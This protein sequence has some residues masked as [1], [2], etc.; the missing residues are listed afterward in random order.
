M[1]QTYG[2][3]T[4]NAFLLLKSPNTEQCNGEKN[5]QTHGLKFEL[6]DIFSTP[7]HEWDPAKATRHKRN[8]QTG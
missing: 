2:P 3:F 7:H 6:S 5:V 8:G 4:Q 1:R